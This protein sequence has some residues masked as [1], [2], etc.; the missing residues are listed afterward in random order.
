MKNTRANGR[1][2]FMM[3]L[4][5]KLKMMLNTKD[6]LKRARKVGLEN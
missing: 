4:V 5:W 3:V 2:I 6:N 1:M